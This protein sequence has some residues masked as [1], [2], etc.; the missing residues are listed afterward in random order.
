MYQSDGNTLQASKTVWL[1]PLGDDQQWLTWE[2]LPIDAS[3][4]QEQVVGG[5]AAG[6]GA[7][8]VAACSGNQLHV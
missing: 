3:Q 8:F 1:P 6:G 2:G 7:V 4:R 5:G